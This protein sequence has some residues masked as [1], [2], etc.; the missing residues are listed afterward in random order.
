L[1]DYG[2]LSWRT[3]RRTG[4]ILEVRLVTWGW[5]SAAAFDFLQSVRRAEPYILAVVKGG[6]QLK[7]WLW[8]TEI[9]LEVLATGLAIPFGIVLFAM[10]WILAV[11]DYAAGNH[12]YMV[13][14]VACLFLPFGEFWFLYRFITTVYGFAKEFIAPGGTPWGGG[15]LGLL[16]NTWDDLLLSFF[17]GG[18]PLFMLGEANAFIGVNGQ[19]LFGQGAEAL[20]NWLKGL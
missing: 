11:A 17:G 13:L 16:G 18:L 19:G 12:L 6:Y 2:I 4:E 5:V 10:A 1:T 7:A 9:P 8:N 15:P 3:K 20:Y 14:D